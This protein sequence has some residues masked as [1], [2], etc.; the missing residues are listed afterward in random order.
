[1]EGGWI[2]R[3][4]TYY[5]R[6]R[7]QRKSN[8]FSEEMTGASRL[9]YSQITV[10]TAF[11]PSKNVERPT[12]LMSRSQGPV[13]GAALGLSCCETAIARVRTTRKNQSFEKEMSRMKNRLT[14]SYDTRQASPSDPCD[15]VECSDGG[16]HVVDYRCDNDEDDGTGA[17][18]LGTV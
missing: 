1:M 13:C 15:L 6:K 2:S 18:L 4:A 10:E 8:R 9:R 3:K 11:I 14:G 17:V 16:D 7:L 12:T 5:Q